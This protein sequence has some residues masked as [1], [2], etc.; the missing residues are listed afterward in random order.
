MVPQ[1]VTVIVPVTSIE[2]GV[3]QV[4][5]TLTVY[6]KLPLVGTGGAAVIM[7]VLLEPDDIS[8]RLVGLIV[9][10]AG[11]EILVTVTPFTEQPPLA[12]TV[13]V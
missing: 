10:Q 2:V 4:L 6:G 9:S 3:P 1:Q 12:E 11:P 7:N 8:P 5:L 13:M